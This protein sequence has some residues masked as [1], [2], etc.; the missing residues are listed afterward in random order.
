M[1][2]SIDAWAHLTKYTGP[3]CGDE[4][5]VLRDSIARSQAGLEPLYVHFTHARL[6]TDPKTA[7]EI[8]EEFGLEPD[9]C[10]EGVEHFE[11]DISYGGYDAWLDW[12]GG[13]NDGARVAIH[14]KGDDDNVVGAREAA[15][16]LEALNPT[17]F[18]ATFGS[19]E[20]D[21]G[22]DGDGGY[23][24]AEVIYRNFVKAYGLAAQGGLISFR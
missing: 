24:G 11:F 19:A 18:E 7:D 3:P 16:V 15:E 9:V 23:E 6:H 1:S 21:F 4:T 10:Y 14:A 13:W 12:L 2:L 8:R 17:L 5:Q 22:D 20:I